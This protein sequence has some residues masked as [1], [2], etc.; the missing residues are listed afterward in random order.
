MFWSAYVD[1]V[2][3]ICSSYLSQKPFERRCRL[4]GASATSLGIAARLPRVA[5]TP[6]RSIACTCS[7][8]RERL[9]SLPDGTFRAR[10][11]FDHDGHKSHIARIKVE[12]MSDL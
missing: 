1:C 10:N 9:A 2:L 7:P 8:L 3:H 6:I 4:T 11:Y 5:A 12:L